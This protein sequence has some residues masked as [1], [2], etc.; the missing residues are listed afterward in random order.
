MSTSSIPL[1]D[2]STWTKEQYL[3]LLRNAERNAPQQYEELIRFLQS[4]SF[5]DLESLVAS[6]NDLTRVAQNS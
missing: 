2:F 4:E 6:R 3:Q 5:S 1:P